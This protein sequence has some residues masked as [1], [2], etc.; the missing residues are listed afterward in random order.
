MNISEEVK[1]RFEEKYKMKS[2]PWS[3]GKVERPIK[4]FLKIILKEYKNPKLLDLGC[5]NG[6]L[7]IWFAEQGFEVQGIDSSQTAIKE[8]R[9]KAKKAKLS[10]LF[11]VGDA[12]KFPYKDELF[13]AVF[14]RGMF[15]HQPKTEWKG[16]VSG[17]RR[18]LNKD[19][20]LYL[21]VFSDKSN[22]RKRKSDR[23][24]HKEKD[25]TGY[26]TYNH[27]FNREV[28]KSTFGKYFEIVDEEEGERPQP[29]GS[30]VRYF[31]LKKKF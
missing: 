20:Y 25:E 26:W 30:M 7:S 22:S 29:S 13:D 3:W 21:I 31:T 23:M 17:I 19:G 8:A 5:G 10:I 2:T 18:V 28:I 11:K 12:L 1:R 27:Y 9:E 24:W 15:H 16:Y 4:R 6:W 14:D